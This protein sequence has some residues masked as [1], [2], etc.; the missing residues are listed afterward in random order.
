VK[1][2]LRARLEKISKTAVS[3]PL[4]AVQLDASRRRTESPQMPMPKNDFF[5]PAQDPSPPPI[6][7]KHA[8]TRAMS[9]PYISH[10]AARSE[11]PSLSSLTDDSFYPSYLQYPTSERKTR[12]PGAGKPTEEHNLRSSVPISRESSTRP[13]PPE[14]P[15]YRTANN[16]ALWDGSGWD[17]MQHATQTNPELGLTVSG[18]SIP[19]ASLA[20]EWN[21]IN[22]GGG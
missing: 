16:A 14:F 17:S 20:G 3:H 8:L 10:H 22:L 7:R 1:A 13:L 5:P 18:M 15:Y 6:D 11:Q 12:A 21:M 9:L 19:R 4:E 2:V